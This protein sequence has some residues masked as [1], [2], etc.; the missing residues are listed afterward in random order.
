MLKI[1]RSVNL[2]WIFYE[3]GSST[4]TQGIHLPIGWKLS[5]DSQQK[6]KRVDCLRLSRVSQSSLDWCDY[7][8]VHHWDLLAKDNGH[9]F[10]RS[11]GN[12]NNE[13]IVR[14][15]WKFG[16]RLW[17]IYLVTSDKYRWATS[18]LQTHR[19]E[20]WK[21]PVTI[22]FTYFIASKTISIKFF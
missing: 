2:H 20:K 22:S 14:N 4:A 17:Q 11:R 6:I 18:Q 19:Q 12:I 8:F 10:F 9:I 21:W 15:G 13:L 7:F 16:F 5:W 3:N 1:Q